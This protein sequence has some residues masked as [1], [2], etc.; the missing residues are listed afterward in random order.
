[1]CRV[2]VCGDNID[3][4]ISCAHV[5]EKSRS[6]D[7]EFWV[8][9]IDARSVRTTSSS[10]YYACQISFCLAAF[11]SGSRLLIILRAP[12]LTRRRAQILTRSFCNLTKKVHALLN[13][14]KILREIQTPN[15]WLRAKAAL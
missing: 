5:F 12:R 15:C 2:S 6:T 10:S 13:T 7:S 4:P 9:W 11:R 1:M 3:V 8:E 14:S